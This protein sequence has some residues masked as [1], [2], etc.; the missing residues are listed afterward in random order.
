MAGAGVSGSWVV[1][2]RIRCPA[3]VAGFAS[4]FGWCG[5][6]GVVGFGFDCFRIESGWMRGCGPRRVSETFGVS[7]RLVAT[8]R[9]RIW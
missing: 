8:G 4:C 9:W 6:C 2:Q 1:V 7:W 3:V 5:R